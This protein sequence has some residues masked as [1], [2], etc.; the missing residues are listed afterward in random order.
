MDRAVL[1]GLIIN[2]LVL[3]ALKHAFPDGSSG[4]LRVE[5]L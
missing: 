2:E 4:C 5:R 3:N 1:C